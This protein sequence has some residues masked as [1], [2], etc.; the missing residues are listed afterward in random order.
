M[1]IRVSKERLLGRFAGFVTIDSETFRERELGER[2]VKELRELG[3]TVRTDLT[4]AEFLKKHP[5][6]YPNIYA[7][8]PSIQTAAND[9]FADDHFISVYKGRSTNMTFKNVTGGI[10]FTVESEGITSVILQALDNE[11]LTGTAAISIPNSGI[12]TV[13]RVESPSSKI[14]LNAPEGETFIPGKAYHFV[15]LPV[16]LSKGIAFTFVKDGQK[17]IKVF[18]TPSEIKRSGFR[19]ITAADKDATWF[20]VSSNTFRV[21]PTQFNLTGNSQTVI[22]T[23]YSTSDYH[24]DVTA[25]WIASDGSPIGSPEGGYI[26]FIKVNANVSGAKR[27]G[28]ASFCTEMTC[29]PVIITQDV[30]DIT[31]LYTSKFVVEDHEICFESI[32][33]FLQFFKS[34][35]THTCSRI[36]GGTLLDYSTYNISICR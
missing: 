25:D 13:K 32:K 18:N 35:G 23:A 22:V 36:V 11:A 34:S 27:T 19:T 4:S 14:V 9:S 3:L 2:V 16:V 24:V 6:S 26:H 17:A 5:E 1:S 12:P 15:T 21:A 8:L 29:H 10:K 28:V 30:L 20:N 31:D 33:L 7:T